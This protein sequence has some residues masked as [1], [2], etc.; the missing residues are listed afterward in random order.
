MPF[1][2]ARTEVN[3]EHVAEQFLRLAGYQTYCPRI[4]ERGRA[5]PLFPS[6]TFIT[7]A[8]QWYRVRWSVGVVALLAGSN[9]EPASV[10]DAIVMELRNREGKD[11]LI[12]LPQSP[13]LKPGDPVR[14]TKGL[15]C[16]LC[17][18]YAGMRGHQRVAVL[19]SALGK[20]ELPQRDVEAVPPL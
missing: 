9:G 4:R 3:R 13:Q 7:A 11:G 20:V 15:L 2:C 5:R 14:I 12:Q 17:G 1:W 10:A 18:L 16:G 19:L 6:Y 8:L